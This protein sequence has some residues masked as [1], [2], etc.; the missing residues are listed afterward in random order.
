MSKLQ[1]KENQKVWKESWSNIKSQRELDDYR[2][3]FDM[4]SV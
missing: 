4:I 2:S 1:L 3:I